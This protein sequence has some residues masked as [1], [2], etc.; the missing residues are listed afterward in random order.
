MPPQYGLPTES[1]ARASGHIGIAWALGLARSTVYAV[2]RR[3]GLNR[4]D[5]LHHVS[6]ETVRYEYRAPGDLLHLDV[7]K[8][9]RVSLR[10]THICM[11]AAGAGVMPAVAPRR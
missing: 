7:K 1:S 11:N 5:R 8:L 3:F 6:R 2:L 4:L 9:G 10:P